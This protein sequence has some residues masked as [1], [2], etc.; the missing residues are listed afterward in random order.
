MGATRLSRDNAN[1]NN[2]S[3]EPWSPPPDPGLHIPESHVVRRP[4]RD[5]HLYHR[6]AVEFSRIKSGCDKRRETA[7]PRRF[8][9]KFP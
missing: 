6:R 4:P 5:L 1:P 7:V 2:F 9:D 8:S 3:R